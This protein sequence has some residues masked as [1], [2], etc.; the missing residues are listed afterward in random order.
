MEEGEVATTAP[1][2]SSRQEALNLLNDGTT[3]REP[4]HTH[5]SR[6]INLLNLEMKIE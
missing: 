3:P 1:Q 4:P 5:G 2:Q 6:P